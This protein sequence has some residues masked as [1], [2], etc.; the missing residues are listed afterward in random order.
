MFDFSNRVKL[1]LLYVVAIIISIA[2]VLY[3]VNS[4]IESKNSNKELSKAEYIFDQTNNLVVSLNTAQTLSGKYISKRAPVFLQQYGAEIEKSVFII[5]TLLQ[6][7]SIQNQEQLL[8]LVNLLEQ[9]TEILEKLSEKKYFRHYLDTLRERSLKKT[10]RKK[11]QYKVVESKIES[12]TVYKKDRRPW[13]ERIKNRRQ[14][15]IIT[16]KQSDSVVHERSILSLPNKTI[17]TLFQSIEYIQHRWTSSLEK[18]YIELLSAE[19]EIGQE[20]S[21]IQTQL[22]KTALDKVVKSLSQKDNSMKRLL[23]A[24]ILA[25]LMVSGLGFMIFRNA[26]SSL[27]KQRELSEAKRVTEELMNSRH[28]LLLSISHDIKAPLVSILSYL[29]FWDKDNLSTDEI[30][31]LS[32]M[33]NSAVHILDM[34]T[35][36]LEYSRLEQKKTQIQNQLIEPIP[37]FLEVVDLFIPMATDK[38]LRLTY[39]FSGLDNVQITIDPLKLRQIV[40]NLISNAIKYTVEG[41]VRFTASL[42]AEHL[43]ITVSDTGIGIPKEKLDSMFESFTQ[44]EN[45]SAHTEGSGFGLFVVK[46]LVDV[47]DGKMKVNS[48]AQG[49]TFELQLP[50][51]NS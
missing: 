41:E 20:I 50:L 37:L 7:L 28:Q 51:R 24:G 39:Q 5:D 9:K 49:T 12:D 23:R 30:R 16:I 19:Q 14:T 15:Q 36:L 10:Y 13:R 29:E 40:T 31:Q 33:Q 48:T 34:L 46:G 38:N 17:D 32:S 11:E 3:F 44:S 43:N 8:L 42:E 35:N 26:Q 21:Q 27:R 47:M 2:A 22:H 1:I 18:Q 6:E 45:R 4:Y 25:F